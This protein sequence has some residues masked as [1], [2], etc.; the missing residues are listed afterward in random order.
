MSEH[1]GTPISP[2]STINCPAALTHVIRT[3]SRGIITRPLT[4]HRTH[5]AIAHR[6]RPLQLCND[7]RHYHTR[8]FCVYTRCQQ[9]ISHHTVWGLRYGIITCHLHHH[10]TIDV[11]NLLRPPPSQPSHCVTFGHRDTFAPS[12]QLPTAVGTHHTLLRHGVCCR[13]ILQLL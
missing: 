1:R 2:H 3:A 9:T 12:L 8:Q 10:P 5:C 7:V 4:F 6:A 13:I 11:I